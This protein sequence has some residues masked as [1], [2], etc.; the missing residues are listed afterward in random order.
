M[1]LKLIARFLLGIS[2]TLIVGCGGDE[3]P[4][5]TQPAPTTPPPTQPTNPA[6]PPPPPPAIGAGLETLSPGTP[7][8]ELPNRQAAL[9]ILV[10]NIWGEGNGTVSSQVRMQ[11]TV[12]GYYPQAVWTQLQSQPDTAQPNSYYLSGGPS[13]TDIVLRVRPASGY[14]TSYTY[15]F[16]YAVNID[17]LVLR[18]TDQVA[19]FEGPKGPSPYSILKVA[20]QSANPIIQQYDI[21]AIVTGGFNGV[22]RYETIQRNMTTTFNNVNVNQPT[23]QPT[24]Q[25][26]YNPGSY[27]PYPGPSGPSNYPGTYP[28]NYPGGYPGGVGGP[29]DY[30]PPGTNPEY[31]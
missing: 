7:L 19:I 13:G 25:P 1:K 18:S 4:P 31:Y 30:V 9:D 3:Q 6:P 21:S 17:G 26:S 15:R 27:N 2:L 22:R 20:Y 23:Q 11:H 12:T 10:K 14:G 5:E 29:Y 16:V 28:G 8:S 24:Q